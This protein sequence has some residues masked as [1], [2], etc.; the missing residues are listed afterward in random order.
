M[1]IPVDDSVDLR[2]FRLPV[3]I[4]PDVLRP[5]LDLGPTL[6][7]EATAAP[8]GSDADRAERHRYGVIEARDEREATAKAAAEFKIPSALRFKISAA[9]LADKK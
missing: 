6:E 8:L 7:G 2:A 3:R 9:K 5:A 1:G 4:R